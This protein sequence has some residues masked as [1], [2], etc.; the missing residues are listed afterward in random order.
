MGTL[1]LEQCPSV[2]Y[3]RRAEEKAQLL[4]G[5]AFYT[6]P[7]FGQKRWAARLVNKISA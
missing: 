1:L 2:V 7:Q 5:D 4:V 6:L 3:H